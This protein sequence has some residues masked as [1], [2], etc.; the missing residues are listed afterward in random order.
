VVRGPESDGEREGEEILKERW[1]KAQSLGEKSG[2][3]LL[4]G[5]IGEGWWAENNAKDFIRDIKALGAITELV[6][7]IN[8]IGGDVFAGMAIYNYLRSL[9]THKTVIVDGLAASIASVVAMAGDKIICPAN[10]MMMVHNPWSFS[11]G[12]GEEMR[13]TAELLDKLRIQMAGVYVARTGL[14]ESVILG[15]MDSETWMTGDEAVESGFADEVGE[16]VEAAASVR[17][18]YFALSTSAGTAR[19]SMKRVKAMRADVT[20]FFPQG[21]QGEG[22]ENT[23]KE[24][25]GMTLEELKGKFPELYAAVLD[26][27]RSEGAKAG[28]ERERAR[29][30]ALDDLDQPGCG[31]IIAKAKYETLSTPEE[32]ALSL[33][34][35]ARAKGALDDRR[36]DAASALDG[37]GGMVPGGMPGSDEREMESFLNVVK[38][39]SSGVRATARASVRGVA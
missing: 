5:D 25:N 33:L 12:D 24:G 37:V 4:Y 35:A 6:V 39:V 38:S 22:G 30:K 21:N 28:A 11:M 34:A 1:W 2:E 27:G 3:L 7:R 10:G 36:Q 19:A 17:D 14:E 15:M 8:S 18:G 23:K 9:K 16:P 20:A 32:C 29:L 13:K 31:E 26:E